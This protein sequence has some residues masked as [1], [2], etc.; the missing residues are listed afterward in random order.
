MASWSLDRRAQA[1]LLPQSQ[2][3]FVSLLRACA[4]LLCAIVAAPAQAQQGGS[5]ANNFAAFVGNTPVGDVAAGQVQVP[6]I[7]WGGDVATFV[8]NGGLTTAQGST[9]SQLG[10][11]M[12]LVNGDDFATQV[13]RYMSGQSPFLR[14]ELRMLALAS[15]VIG[16]DPRT[17][18]VV[19]LQLTWSAGDHMVGRPTIATLNDIKGKKIALQRNGPHVGMLDDILRSV[20][21]GWNDVTIVWASSLTGDGG[22][23]DLFRKDPTIDAAFVISPDML[24]LTG[25]LESKGT[26]AEGT[27]EN[28]RVVV[29]T[30]QMSRAIADVYAVRKDWFDKNRSW[31][32]KFAAGYFAGSEKVV[33]LRNRFAQNSQRDQTYFAILQQAQDILGKEVLPT[34]DVDAH[35]LLLDAS[36]VGLPGNRGFFTDKGNLDGFDAKS[37]A[38][39]DLAVGQGYAKIRA[40]LM[41]ANLDYDAIAKLGNLKFVTSQGGDRFAAESVDAFPTDALDDKTLLSFT[42]SFEPNQEAFDAAVYGPEFLRAVQ[43]ASTFGS[44]VVAVRGHADPTKVLVDFVKAGLEKKVLTRTG[45]PGNYKYFHKGKELSL[46][47]GEELATIINSGALDGA[48]TN[49]RDTLQAALNLSRARAEAVRD[50]VIAFAKEQGLRLD[51]SQIQPVGVGVAEPVIA[52]PRNAQDAKQNMRVEFRLV[53]VPAE[54]VK[55]GDFDY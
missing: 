5:P 34:L 47:S 50:A 44:A 18:P 51:K 20:R 2:S 11:D 17:K 3:V 36:F 46:A 49:P 4:L 45:T 28:A 29:S 30:A 33:E 10:L 54:S 21:L 55:P 22:P 27:V 40:G 9:F 32:E 16:S 31:V 38:A 14:G 26:G 39:L 37:K 8:A 12:Q 43:N 53:R 41:T 19:F 6:F 13:K 23:A 48:S 52:T 35:G 25:G 1:S 15:E 7:T 42:I 24:G